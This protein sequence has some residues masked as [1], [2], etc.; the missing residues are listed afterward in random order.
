MLIP[1]FDYDSILSKRKI[2]AESQVIV[3]AS[4]SRE[5]IASEARDQ[6]VHLGLPPWFQN[7]LFTE[8]IHA[9]VLPMEPEDAHCRIE[10]ELMHNG[11]GSCLGPLFLFKQTQRNTANVYIY[12]IFLG[13]TLKTKTHPIGPPNCSCLFSSLP[14]KPWHGGHGS[15]ISRIQF[16]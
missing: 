7:I 11:C 6:Q 16:E 14:F 2:V 12:I 15:P 5:T 3:G 8:G 1:D 10:K 9:L 13:G 4:A